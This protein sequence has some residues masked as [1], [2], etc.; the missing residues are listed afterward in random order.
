MTFEEPPVRV[1]MMLYTLIE[2]HPGRH[3]EYNRWYERDH[4]YSGVM[5]LPGTLSGQRWVAT[6][7]LRALRLPAESSV[8]PDPA[9]GS[10][11]TTYYVD[12]KRIPE[13]D[14]EAS[15]AVRA[16]ATAGRLWPE[17][18]HVLT[19]FVDFAH[20]VYRDA[21]PVPAVQTLDH[22]YPGLVTVVGRGPD[23]ATRAAT[24][25]A[26]RDGILP[27]AL[28]GSPVAAVLTFTMRPFE[29]ERPPDLPADL[30]PESR[31]LQL[32]FVEVAPDEVWA[33]TFAPL[34]ARFDA[35]TRVELEWMGGFVPT[36]PGTDTHVDG[37]DP[38]AVV[39]EYFRRVRARDPRLTELFADDA[40]LVG[41]GT[42][43]EG[44]PAIDAFYA[45]INAVQAPVPTPRGPLLVDGHRVAAEIDIIVAGG[46]SVHVIDLFEVVDG[47]ITQLTYFL[48]DH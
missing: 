16:L 39:A 7:A 2:P 38:R 21:D 43:T 32:W 10:F 19:R 33:D 41:L 48:A 37:P 14:V 40:C 15:A 12:A 34:A 23:G 25:A 46:P 36:V 4:F 22:R 1:G 5:T 35:D 27:T 6:P 8:V 28:T 44:R 3:R 13:W 29:G 45:E 17:R 42:R 20:A 30:D 26:L 18:D 9:R 47:R 11:L 24:L 31:F